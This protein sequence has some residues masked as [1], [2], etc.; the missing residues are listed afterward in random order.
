MTK[1]FDFLPNVTLPTTRIGWIGTGVMGQNMCRHLIQAGYRATIYNRTPS[2][3]SPLL[4][5]GAK[6]AATPADVARESDVVFTMVGYPCDVREILLGENG[7][8]STL[9]A[10]SVVADMTTSSPELAKILFAEAQKRRIHLLDAPVSGGD[11]GAKEAKLSIMIGGEKAV[12]DMLRP[13]F[14]LLGQNIIYHGKAGS[15]QHAKMVNQILVATNMIGQCEGLLYA[16][17]AGLNLDNVLKSI[18]AGAAGSW[19][20]SN[21]APRILAGNFDPGFYVEHLVKDLGIALEE[22]RRMS[23]TLPGLELADILFRLT[24]AHGYARKGTQA[25]LLALAEITKT[26]WK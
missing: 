23:L 1:Q 17:R 18:A 14:E 12:A 5:L 9:A 15:G 3:A 11:I 10:N 22:C 6:W 7:L 19:S 2:K 8:F 20:L 25:L 16:Y 26:D 4:E 13:C 21:L 24:V